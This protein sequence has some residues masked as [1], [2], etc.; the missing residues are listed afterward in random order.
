MDGVLVVDALVAVL[1]VSLLAPLLVGLLPRLPVPQVVLLLAGGVLIG[2]QV[3][4]LSS[5]GEV[6]VLA[7]VGLGFVF[8]LA[9]YEVD[10][11]LFG[12]DAGRRAVTAWFA[13]LA[14]ALGA[15]A[16]LEAVGVVHA[17]VP[18]ALGLTTTAL[19][20]L[21]PVLRER[22]L[23]RGGSDATCWP[24]ARSGSS[25]RSSASRCSSERR[26]ASPPSRRSAVSP[27][28]RSC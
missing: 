1:A 16:L 23:L 20:T 27:S 19:G 21:L 17:F 11:R 13:G 8:L 5:P 15:V 9:G 14:L 2:P 22:D 10:L 6:Q 7:D 3:L 4:G 26:A 18:V 28:S 25:S 12:E 24:P